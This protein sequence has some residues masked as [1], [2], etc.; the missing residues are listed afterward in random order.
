[1]TGEPWRVAVEGHRE[2]RRSIRQLKDKAVTQELKGAHKDAADLVVPPAR[3]EAPE[4][5]G[6]LAASIRPASN[7]KGAIVRAGSARVVPY[8]GPVHWGWKARNIPENL[9]LIR[10]AAA[11]IKQ[12]AELFEARM[13]ALIDRYIGS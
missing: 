8:A 6:S 9:F 12:V 7:V 4:R 10:A 1:M 5:S 3:V 13:R 11:R 2:L